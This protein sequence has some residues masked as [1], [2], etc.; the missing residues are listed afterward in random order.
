MV[1]LIQL[2]LLA[3]FVAFAC[4]SETCS[5]PNNPEL[6]GVGLLQHFQRRHTADSP[7]ADPIASIFPAARHTAASLHVQ[8]A[9][10][11]VILSPEPLRGAPVSGLQSAQSPQSAAAQLPSVVAQPPD[12]ATKGLIAGV[13]Q[14][15][16]QEARSGMKSL[17]GTTKPEVNLNQEVTSQHLNTSMKM[18]Q[19]VS[20]VNQIAELNT[21]DSII[22]DLAAQAPRSPKVHDGWSKKTI[23]DG[24]CV[25][26]ALVI[27]FLFLVLADVI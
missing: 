14:V 25:V 24:L 6:A 10:V 18:D 8:P 7:A 23:F 16:Q 12:A 15:T 27:M 13:S 4:G 5:W 17:V 20:L 22:A 21:D 9:H 1:R 11:D 3:L 2:A 19:K 26:G